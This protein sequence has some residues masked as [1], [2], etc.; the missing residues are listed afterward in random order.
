MIGKEYKIRHDSG[1]NFHRVK[2]DQQF[3]SDHLEKHYQQKL[4]KALEFTKD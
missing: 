2:V 4:Q 3:R 1:D